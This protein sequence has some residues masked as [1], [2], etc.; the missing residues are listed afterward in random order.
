MI[1]VEVLA[2]A[3]MKPI[4]SISNYFNPSEARVGT[5]GNR[6]NGRALVIPSA[7]SRASLI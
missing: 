2:G 5:F 1:A 6:A 7:V 3:R 4:V